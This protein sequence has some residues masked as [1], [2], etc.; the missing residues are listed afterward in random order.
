MATMPNPGN[1]C[2]I[3]GQTAHLRVVRGATLCEKCWRAAKDIFRAG[4]CT[5]CGRKTMCWH[6]GNSQMVCANCLE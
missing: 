2:E 4:A 5:I 6:A 1:R 3:C